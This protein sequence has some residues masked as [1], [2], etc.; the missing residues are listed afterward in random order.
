MTSFGRRVKE[1]RERLGM[2]RLQL[3]KL[4]GTSHSYI[5]KVEN[6]DITPTVTRA[7]QI[8]R[9]LRVEVAW[10]IE[11]ERP[12]GLSAQGKQLARAIAAL[13]PDERDVVVRLVN[14]LYTKA[15]VAAQA[16]AHDN[17]RPSE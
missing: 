16:E 4:I 10:L 5:S 1:A 14:I 8:A 3:A 7:V 17:G 9:A 11:G 12:K 13:P 2:S 6:G 15:M